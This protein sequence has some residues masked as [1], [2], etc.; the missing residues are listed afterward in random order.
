[1][2]K[3]PAPEHPLFPDDIDAAAIAEAQKAA[4]VLG[5]PFCEECLKAQIA[6]AAGR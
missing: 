3:P 4:A 6:A 2:P 5:I 1:V